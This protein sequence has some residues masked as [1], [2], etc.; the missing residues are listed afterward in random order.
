MG[1][2]DAFSPAYVNPVTVNNFGPQD[3]GQV[4]FQFYQAPQPF[5]PAP[6]Q[7]NADPVDYNTAATETGYQAQVGYQ[8]EE[9]GAGQDYHQT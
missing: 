2:P 4:Q 5:A 8:A 7:V 1:A 6:F 3:T 9:Y